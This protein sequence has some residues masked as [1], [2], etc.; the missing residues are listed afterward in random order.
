MNKLKLEKIKLSI[1]NVLNINIDDPFNSMSRKRE[2]VDAR[3]IYF[4]L[5]RE[6]TT[7]S[8]ETLGRSLTPIKD[9]ST[10]IHA[11]K[12]ASVFMEIDRVFSSKLISVKQEYISLYN[13]EDT[14]DFTLE[15][16][17]VRID[18]LEEINDS[19]LNDNNKLRTDLIRVKDLISRHKK[20]L[21]DVG[22]LERGS[23]TLN[24]LDEKLK[25]Y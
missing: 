10:V 8:Y 21:F 14:E 5:A 17:I 25:S 23:K 19:L 24:I 11:M 7:Y 3:M 1:L 12:Q 15:K 6:L 13:K 9:H 16:A 4:Y 18:S 22:Y 2:N 20:Y